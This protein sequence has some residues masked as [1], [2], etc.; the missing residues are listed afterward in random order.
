[1]QSGVCE[2]SPGSGT[3]S[4]WWEELV[5]EVGRYEPGMKKRSCGR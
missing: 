3:S 2:V 4:L 1:M 5:K